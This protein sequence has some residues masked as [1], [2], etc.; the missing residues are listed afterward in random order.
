MNSEAEILDMLVEIA[1]PII[2]LHSKPEARGR[3]LLAAAVGCEVCRHFGIAAAPLSVAVEIYNKAAVDWI[4]AGQPGGVEG[5]QAC[6]AWIIV[7]DHENRQPHVRG[8]PGHL[9]VEIEGG[10]GGILD[11]DL[12]QFQ[13]PEKQILLPHAA[14]FAIDPVRPWRYTIGESLL[15]YTP[16]REDQSFRKTPG[17][18]MVGRGSAAAGMAIRTIK[19][20]LR[21]R[22]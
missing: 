14:S 21:R 3:C 4:T 17:W 6:G 8:W 19:E 11:L 16:R 1:P 13:R 10:G 20:R 2:A 22:A 9:V 15:C 5:Y 12:Q 7:I 18:R